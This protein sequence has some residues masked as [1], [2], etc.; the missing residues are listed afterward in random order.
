MGRT[1]TTL[2][3]VLLVGLGSVVVVVATSDAGGAARPVL[4]GAVESVIAVIAVLAAVLAGAR[5]NGTRRL[6]DFFLAGALTFLAAAQVLFGMLPTAF[7][8]TSQVWPWSAAAGR[9]IGA[10]ALAAAAVVPQ[11]PVERPRRLVVVLSVAGALVLAL[12][13]GLFLLE[14]SALPGG[15]TPAGEL[16]GRA[17]VYAVQFA[18]FV[19][20][21]VAF[22]G[23]ARRWL[24]DRERVYEWLATAAGLGA[25]ARLDYLLDPTAGLSSVRVGDVLRVLFYMLVVVGLERD[26]AGR[27]AEAAVHEER[28]RIARDLHDGLAQDLAFIARRARALDDDGELAA[29]ADR[30]LAESRRAITAL[31]HPRSE[32]LD[33]TLAA[34]LDGLAATVGTRLVFDLS[35]V[36]GV[37]V[38]QREALVAIAHEAVSNAARHAEADVV[39]VELAQD[40]HV[41]LR[42]RDDGVG[43]EPNGVPRDRYGIAGMRERAESIGARFSLSSRAGGG[44]EVEVVLG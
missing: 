34:A 21:A 13:G 9:L 14:G 2:A 4:H 35:P 42:V 19:A 27:A 22:A 40:G 23:F 20:F 8:A 33:V 41:R 37:T 12:M 24:H 32:P 28:R 38:D 25:I 11:I 43:F 36:T 29:A 10:V 3:L 18:T 26:A 30:A 16:E 17:A 7:S 15:L 5:A 44:T 6:D 39:R 31:R 1:R